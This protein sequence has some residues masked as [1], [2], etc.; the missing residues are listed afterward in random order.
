ML[1][2]RKRK[3]KMSSEEEDAAEAKVAEAKKEKKDI[4]RKRKKRARARFMMYLSLFLSAVEGV[5]AYYKYGIFQEV[6]LDTFYSD[7]PNNSSLGTGY[8]IVLWFGT[9]SVLF[10]IILLA[11]IFWRRSKWYWG[12]LGTSG[13]AAFFDAI[14]KLLGKSFFHFFYYRVS[15]FTREFC[16]MLRYWFS[17]GSQEIRTSSI[18]FIFFYFYQIYLF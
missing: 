16:Y 17:F 18:F 11:F 5:L 6:L 13:F 3:N 12:L 7:F 4:I 15:M 9:F 1:S 14:K 8:K 10:Y 2:P